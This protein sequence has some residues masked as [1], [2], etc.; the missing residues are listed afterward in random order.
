MARNAIK[1]DFRSKMAQKGFQDGPKGFPRW[2]PAA[3]LKKKSE[4]KKLRID[5]KWREMDSKVIFG[6]PK[7]L[8]AAIL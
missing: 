7:W 2:Q 3:I 5:L 6:H 8:P 1:S 4:K